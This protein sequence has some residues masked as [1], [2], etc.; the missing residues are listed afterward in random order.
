MSQI[1]ER[2]EIRTLEKEVLRK[3]IK[4]RKKVG[5]LGKRCRGLLV[6][7]GPAPG[8]DQVILQVGGWREA[9]WSLT[10][11][12]V[13]W[14]LALNWWPQRDLGFPVLWATSPGA[15]TYEKCH[16]KLLG[17]SQVSPDKG[18]SHRA[19]GAERRPSCSVCPSSQW[20]PPAPPR[21]LELYRLPDAFKTKLMGPRT[22]LSTLPSNE[23]SPRPSPCRP[24]LHSHPALSMCWSPFRLGTRPLPHFPHLPRCSHMSTLKPVP[25]GATGT[26]WALASL[27]ISSGPCSSPVFSI[28]SPSCHAHLPL[29]PCRALPEGSSCGP[30]FSIITEQTN[31]YKGCSPQASRQHVG[32]RYLKMVCQ[33]QKTDPP[34]GEPRL[35]SKPKVPISFPEGLLPTT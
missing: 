29:V 24:P 22:W 12:R 34:I 14:F 32:S 4:R 35:L 26:P 1:R 18:I 17:F 11:P 21:F 28:L 25:R 7:P 5:T 20:H 3:L 16:V 6:G 2:K 8:S 15:S 33:K 10:S 23:H 19:G 31:T 27:E 9:L 13:T 30:T